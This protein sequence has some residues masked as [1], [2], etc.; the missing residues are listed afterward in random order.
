VTRLADGR[1][2]HLSAEEIARETLRQ[3]DVGTR[4]PSIRSLAAALQVT[5]K[6]IYHYYA[7][8]ADVVRAAIRLVWEEAAA[9]VL[10]QVAEPDH[11][12]RDPIDFLVIIALAAR[13]AFG[14][15]HRIATRLAFAPESDGRSAG[16]V[17]VVAAAFEQL[18]LT[19]DEAGLGLYSFLTYTLGSVL[20][21]AS[22]RLSD[23]ILAEQGDLSPPAL[24]SL[25]NRPGHAPA[26]GDETT[27][28]VDRI[29]DAR[30]RRQPPNDELFVAGLRLLLANLRARP[31]TPS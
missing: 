24:S 1:T 4:E 10:D 30:A 11:D 17:T 7:T 25:A 26:V 16:A 22:Q 21:E 2:T 31:N 9:E 27:R 28:A 23:E 5:P 29:M 18:G 19:G 20:L 12:A 6:A 3:F 13:H 14:R 15:H 8:R